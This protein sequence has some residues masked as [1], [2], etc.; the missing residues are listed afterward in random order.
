MVKRVFIS[1][2]KYKFISTALVFTLIIRVDFEVILLSSV[3]SQS[4]IYLRN[5]F[6]LM[7]D[8]N[9]EKCCSN[10]ILPN[11]FS[12]P[13]PLKQT[14]PLGQLF[15]P[16]FS[17]FFKTAVLTMGMDILTMTTYMHFNS[18]LLNLENPSI[19]SGATSIS[20]GIFFIS[21]NPTYL[22]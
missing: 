5:K 2:Y 3:G 4:L 18:L 1:I 15:S 12:T 16:K 17:Q 8:P 19:S 7:E 11:S 13:S 6:G 20:D 21:I 10:G 14:D 22:Y 9:S